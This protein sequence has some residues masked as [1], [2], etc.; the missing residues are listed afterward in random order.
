MSRQALAETLTP[1]SIGTMRTSAT[2]SRNAMYS[3]RY[4]KS[5][6]LGIRPLVFVVRLFPAVKPLTRADL[7]CC[8]ARV[9][10]SGERALPAA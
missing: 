2:T 10:G 6:R 1:T 7:A 5:V 8:E 9:K 3:A 4:R